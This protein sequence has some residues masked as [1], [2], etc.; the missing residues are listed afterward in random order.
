MGKES[1]QSQPASLVTPTFQCSSHQP[2]SPFSEPFGPDCLSPSHRL[3]LRMKDEHPTL[4]L[5]ENLK[6]MRVMNQTQVTTVLTGTGPTNQEETQFT[7]TRVRQVGWAWADCGRFPLN[8]RQFS[9]NWH[10]ELK[11]RPDNAANSRNGRSLF[12]SGDTYKHAQ[13]C[14]FLILATI[15]PNQ[16]SL[17][18]VPPTILSHS[19]LNALEDYR[20]LVFE[21]WWKQ[22]W[23]CLCIS[24]S[25]SSLKHH[26]DRTRSRY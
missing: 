1:A 11:N 25:L 22:W 2:N 24:N 3:L 8:R 7:P 20:A 21:V 26:W 5:G 17:H 16:L 23:H 15:L 14:L 19:F 4:I 6:R 10:E 9:S 13:Y 18:S 12:F